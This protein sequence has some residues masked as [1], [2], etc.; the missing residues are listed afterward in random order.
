M[1]NNLFCTVSSFLSVLGVGAGSTLGPCQAMLCYR[2]Q[3]W[4][5]SFGQ[6]LNS[7]E[8]GKKS[9]LNHGLPIKANSP[10]RRI[11]KQY[12]PSALQQTMISYGTKKFMFLRSWSVDQGLYI[13]VGTWRLQIIIIPNSMTSRAYI[14]MESRMACGMS[15]CYACVVHLENESQAANKRVWR[16]WSLKPVRLWCGRLWQ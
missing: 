8:Q 5:S 2:W 13:L 3:D 15:A 4:C 12:G 6:W 9:I 16:R 7:Y 14:S 11:E 10:R 1:D